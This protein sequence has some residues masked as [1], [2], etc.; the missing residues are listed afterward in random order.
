MPTLRLTL[1][2]LT[3]MLVIAAGT[4]SLFAQ[5]STDRQRLAEAT[6]WVNEYARYFKFESKLSDQDK[7]HLAELRVKVHSPSTSLEDRQAALKDF[8][9]MIFR[10]AG[11]TPQPPEQALANFARNNGQVIHRLVTDPNSKPATGNTP[12]G[13]LGRVEKHGHGPVPI[14]LIADLRADGSLYQTF[15]ERNADRYTM[16]AVTLPGYGG[17][18]APPKAAT[19]DLTKTLWWNGAKQGVLDLIAKNNLNKPVVLGTANSAYLAA[20]LA[21]EHP[22]KVRAAVLLD[23]FVYSNFRSLANPDYPATL[24][25]RPEML[26]KQPGATGMIADFMPAMLLSRE[27]AEARIKALPPAQLGQFFGGMHDLDRARALAI[28]AAVN[29][30]P[31]AAKYNVEFFSTDPTPAFKDLKVPVLAI[32]AIHD[33]NSPGQ[34]SPA[35]GEWNELKLRYPAIPLTVVPFQNTRTYITEDAPKEFDAALEAFLAGKPV[36]GKKG[37]RELAARPSPRAAVMQAIGPMEVVI[38]YG[39]PQVN[40]RQVW[41]Q[42]VPYNRLWRAGANEAT[43]INF[44]G[45]VLIEGQKLAAGM[46]TLFMIPTESEWTVVFNKVLNQ[47]GHF[48]YPPEFDVLKVKVKPQ[49]AEHQEYLNYSFEMLSPTSANVVMRWEKVKVPFKVELEPAKAAASGN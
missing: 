4:D 29:S 19:L 5:Q 48:T 26:M 12:L 46:Y 7:D 14:I 21:L 37:D 11:T 33:D 15:M 40:K 28:N 27:A 25:E 20:R 13:Q 18:P 23:G 1:R 38:H 31:R 39:S 9:V 47:W 42:L 16:Y 44:G 2:S 32:P 22:D 45:D 3:L 43:V 41:G 24:A 17:T 36:E 34:G 30:D 35:L 10:V 8:V 49:T 6:A